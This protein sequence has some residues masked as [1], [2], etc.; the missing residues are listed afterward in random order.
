MND[1]IDIALRTMADIEAGKH[2]PTENDAFVIY[3]GSAELADLSTGVL[4][5]TL[6]PSEAA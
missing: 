1:L 6:N 3:R 2:F 5:C 4:C